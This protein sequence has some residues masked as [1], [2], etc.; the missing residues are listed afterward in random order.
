[1]E[2]FDSNYLLIIVGIVAIILEIILGA[3]TGFDLLLIGVIFIVSGLLGLVSQSF[4]IALISISI[5]SFAYV[6]FARGY[7]K[8][9]LI[10]KTKATNVDALIGK[11]GIV[12]KAITLHKAGQ[13][14]VEG[15]IWRS[16]SEQAIDEKAH[17]VVESVSGV[18]LLVKKV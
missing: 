5:L 2:R 13:V 4:T 18:T 6:A 12:I 9:Q 1:M 17:V 10:I 7:I 8:K 16:E 15:E 3:L 14:K 11:K